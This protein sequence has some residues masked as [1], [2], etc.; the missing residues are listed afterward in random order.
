MS[1]IFVDRFDRP[2]NTD[3]SAKAPMGIGYTEV[4]SD[5]QIVS[6][7]LKAIGLTTHR[8][9][10][11]ITMNS[12]DYYVQSIIKIATGF[13]CGLGIMGRFVDTSNYY[14]AYI[15]SVSQLLILDKIVAGV[16]TQLATFA[17]GYVENTD[18]TIKLDLSGSAIKVYVNGTQRISVTD[19]ALAAAGK[20]GFYTDYGNGTWND[21]VIST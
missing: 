5:V 16:T 2:D 14:R 1:S 19:S 4:T 21:L 20:P 9:T 17:G 12:A 13:G 7:K 8:A 6:G 11:D 18:Y 10:L 15:N 3:I